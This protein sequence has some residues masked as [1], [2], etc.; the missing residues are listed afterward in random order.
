MAGAILFRM[1]SMDLSTPI[2]PYLAGSL[3]RSSSDSLDPVLAPDGTDARPRMPSSSKMSTS[4]VGLP[5]ESSISLALTSR[6]VVNLFS[7]S[8]YL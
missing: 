7:V 6:I 1:L 2:P 8:D 3:S 5:R 4:R